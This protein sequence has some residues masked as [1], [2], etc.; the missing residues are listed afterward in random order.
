MSVVDYKASIKWC[1][2]QIPTEGPRES[3]EVPEEMNIS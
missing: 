2:K 1:P 3:Q